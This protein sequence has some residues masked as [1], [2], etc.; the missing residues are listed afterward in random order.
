MNIKFRSYPNVWNTCYHG[1]DNDNNDNNN[2][3]DVIDKDNVLMVHTH[4]IHNNNNKEV[5]DNNA[6]ILLLKET[7][8]K[9]CKEIC[10]PRSLHFQQ[11]NYDQC[12][13]Y[14]FFTPHV[15]AKSQKIK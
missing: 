12:G 5:D 6:G 7:H 11:S 3:T 13:H 8:C 9:L 10:K 2:N 1:H 4:G 15:N 14:F